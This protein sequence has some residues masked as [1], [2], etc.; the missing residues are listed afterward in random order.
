[1]CVFLSVPDVEE[2]LTE[3]DVKLDGV[4]QKI[5]LIA[6]ELKGE[7]LHQ[8]HRAF[9]PGMT[10]NTYNG[11]LTCLSSLIISSIQGLEILEMLS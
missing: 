7:D 3:A 2:I 8:F 4:K 5:G 6:E 10:T 9:T 11:Q 1:M